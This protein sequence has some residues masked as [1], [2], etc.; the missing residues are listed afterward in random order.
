MF[1][2]SR[3]MEPEGVNFIVEHYRANLVMYPLRFIMQ[4]FIA[5]LIFI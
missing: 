1:K 2:T 3:I 5:L 4:D